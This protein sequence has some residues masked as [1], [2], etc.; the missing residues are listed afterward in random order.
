MRI[1]ISVNIPLEKRTGVEEY[2]YHLLWNLSSVDGFENHQFFILTPQ[3]T[4]VLKEIAEG[5]KTDNKRYILKQLNWPFKKFWTIIRLSWEVHKNK[6]DILFTPAHLHPFLPKKTKL[7]VTIQGLEFE[8]L[9]KM[10]SFLK[11]KFLRWITKRNTKRANR[12]IVPSKSTKQDL[13][14]Y[15][16]DVFKKVGAGKIFVVYHGV[17]N[18]EVA[19]DATQ[20]AFDAVQTNHFGPYLIYIGRQDKRK[21]INGLIKALRILKNDHKIPHK[22]ILVGPNTGY[23]IPND[24]K[25]EIICTGYVSDEK[26]WNLLKNADVFVYPSFYEGFGLPILEAQKVG[27]PVVCSS[28]SSMPEIVFNPSQKEPS[29]VL[30]NPYKPSEIAEGI[31][32]IIRNQTFSDELVKRGY[33][34]IQRFSWPKCAKE[35]LDVILK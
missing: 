16:P 27:T 6:Y 31:H 25:N 33:E 10:Y 26:K 28:I 3:I 1:A 19:F 7:I 12:I 8:K 18:P 29:A 24:L 4:S 14:R 9:P 32:Q 35:T 5:S 30:V 11:R 13:L 2:I 21:N 17:G 34:N 23:K 15:Y 22:L 20:A